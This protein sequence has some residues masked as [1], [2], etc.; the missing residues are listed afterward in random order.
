MQGH[1]SQVE[2]NFWVGDILRR[3]TML[4]S[5]ELSLLLRALRFAA[6]KHN[7]QRHKDGRPFINHLIEITEMLT[8]GGGISAVSVLAASL[9]QYTIEGTA[10]SP[11]EIE[12]LFGQQVLSLVLEVTDDKS[13]PMRMQIQT[14]RNR[15]RAA[16]QIKLAQRI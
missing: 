14:T 3:L 1:H 7:D 13:F 9:L 10:T 11:D 12:T 2:D 6:V 16:K 4:K 15:S 8:L 5:E